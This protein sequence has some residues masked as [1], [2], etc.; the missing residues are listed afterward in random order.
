MLKWGGGKFEAAVDATNEDAFHAGAKWDVLAKIWL[1]LSACQ[2]AVS[3]TGLHP[4]DID[5]Q[6]HNPHRY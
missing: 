2:L 5:L 1:E 4:H 3:T 6:P